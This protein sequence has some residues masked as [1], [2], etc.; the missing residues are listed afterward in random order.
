MSGAAEELYDLFGALLPMAVCG[1]L[2]G[3]LAMLTGRLTGC[4][5]PGPGRRGLPPAVWGVVCAAYLL[6]LD[7]MLRPLARLGQSGTGGAGLLV[8]GAA[9]G[10]APAPLG[11]LLGGAVQ[12][13]ARPGLSGLMG[14]L[15]ALSLAGAAVGAGRRLWRAARGARRLRRLR[16][17]DETV[18]QSAAFLA[19]A[20]PGWGRRVRVYR[21]MGI[22]APFARGLLRPAV[23]LPEG[24]DDPEALALSLRHELLHLRRGHLWLRSAAGLA[25]LVYW[26]DPIARRLPG[27]T[28][29]ACELA[30]DA[31]VVR[32]LGP[33]GRKA[34]AG[35]LLRCADGAEAICGGSGLSRAGAQLAARFE[36]L[37]QGGGRGPRRA[38][39]MAAG[40]VL[41]LP[42]TAGAAGQARDALR[43]AALLRRALDAPQTYLYQPGPIEDE[44]PLTD[45]ARLIEL[46]WP[47][48]GFRY[49]GRRQVRGLTIAAGVGTPIVA[50][51]DGV[52][53]A[54]TDPQQ[55][56]DGTYGRTIVLAHGSEPAI[57]T[58]YLHCDEVLVRPG[59]PVRAGQQIGT[60]GDSG[61]VS[62]PMCL[63]QVRIGGECYRPERWYPEA[64]FAMNP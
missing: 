14:L 37:R 52:V 61:A 6:P 58:S 5:S 13:A 33:D 10:T 59:Q 50:A 21:L 23:Y 25:A 11:E 20:G 26:F 4:L 44:G 19:A 15:A 31:A 34:Y 60:T 51:A 40:L 18:R 49:C 55:P 46:E 29:L 56:P 12:L 7:R 64:Y 47:V 27:Q 63:Y 17:P 8:G 36:A 22:A 2:A 30:C 48:P 41:T 32:G 16:R 38:A 57:S 1:M 3:G 53:L 45:P 35:L 43:G 39:L 62:G 42:L 54:A 24:L 28:E 9:R